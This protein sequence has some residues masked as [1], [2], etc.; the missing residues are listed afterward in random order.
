V[1][2]YGQFCSVARALDLLG[3]RWAMLVV[4]ELLLGPKR[5]TDLRDGLPGVGTNVLAVRLREL[6]DVGILIRQKLPPPAPATLYALTDDGHALRPVV[7]ELAR[8]G[9]RLMDGPKRGDTMRVGWLV[10]SLAIS[11]SASGMREDSEL[12][13]RVDGEPYTVTVRNGRFEARQRAA[14]D[15]ISVI[16]AGPA[17]L[18]QLATG[19]ER[20][21]E[22][23]S[24]G[25]IAIDGD[26][27]AARRFLDAV[28]GA[29]L[30]PAAG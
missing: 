5:Y 23:E 29:W 25:K 19:R 2:Q 16:N 9:L 10:Y 18:F 13:M 15:P 14:V 3:D 6:E 20:R 28:H 26:T 22:L 24:S 17:S 27:R 1:K 30:E 4:R 11:A 12:E 21:R 8:W 7:D